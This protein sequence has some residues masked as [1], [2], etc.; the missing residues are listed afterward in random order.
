MSDGE[1]QRK[2][3]AKEVSDLLEI[4]KKTL[5]TLED[6]GLIPAVPRDWRGWRE[7]D[8]SHLDAIRKYQKSK[9]TGAAKAN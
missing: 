2:Y 3:K 9:V 1:L 6:R 8:K 4:S 7:Y 5:F